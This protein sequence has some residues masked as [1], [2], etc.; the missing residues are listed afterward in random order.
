MKPSVN[1]LRREPSTLVIR[2]STTVTDRLH[3]SGQSSG[4]TDSFTSIMP[5]RYPRPGQ[6]GSALVQRWWEAGGGRRRRACERNPGKSLSN[7]DAVSSRRNPIGGQAWTTGPPPAESDRRR[8]RAGW[9]QPVSVSKITLS[10]RVPAL[11]GSFIGAERVAK[12]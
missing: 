12:R 1:G 6:N 3:V 5:D 4:Q 8:S 11:R 10:H 9:G 7:C 2:P